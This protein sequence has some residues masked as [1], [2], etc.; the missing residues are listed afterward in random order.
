[1]GVSAVLAGVSLFL[2]SGLLI[3]FFVTENETVDRASNWLFVVFYVFMG[4]TMIEVHGLYVDV[5]A[6]AWVLTL[7]GVAVLAFLLVVQVL[8][9]LGGLDFRRV[10][11]AT[12][13]GFVVILLW[14]LGASILIVAE[15]RLP[16]ALG[17][18]GVAVIG[19]AMVV[20]GISAT[21]RELMMGEQTPG[22]LI[23]ALYGLVLVGVSVWLFWLGLATVT[24]LS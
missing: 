16:T 7:I 1:M 17:W 13:V 21:D 14:M 15:G 3:A 24:P 9:A 18:L 22:P 6:W 23:N 12:T 4:W 10:A 19:A 8:V 11:I 5:A 20:L 2:A